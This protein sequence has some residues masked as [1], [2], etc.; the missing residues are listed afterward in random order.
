MVGA[1]DDATG[2]PAVTVVV[3]TSTTLPFTAILALLPVVPRAL[4][5][6]RLLALATAR[7]AVVN[8]VLAFLGTRPK[9]ARTSGDSL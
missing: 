6:A 3:T 7:C 4:R 8:G 9:S 1:A 5:V 2:G